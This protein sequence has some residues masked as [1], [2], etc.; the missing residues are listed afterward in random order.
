MTEALTTLADELLSDSDTEVVYGP[1]TRC[2][3]LLRYGHSRESICDFCGCP[4][5]SVLQAELAE[6]CDINPS[7]QVSP[8]EREEGRLFIAWM[9]QGSAGTTRLAEAAHSETDSPLRG[10]LHHAPTGSDQGT[11][12]ADTVPPPVPPR[13]DK[14]QDRATRHRLCRQAWTASQPAM[15]CLLCYYHYDATADGDGVLFTDLPRIWRCPRCGK[16]AFPPA[17]LSSC[18]QEYGFVARPTP[19][20]WRAG[21]GEALEDSDGSE[22][23]AWKSR[24]STESATG[25]TD[26]HSEDE[27]EAQVPGYTRVGTAEAVPRPSLVNVRTL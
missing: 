8:Q 3:R 14:P 24:T 13:A 21:R 16:A 17:G 9:V 27:D 2:K 6:T 18:N 5:C 26:E 12:K 11:S 20:H 7:T 10:P 25:A 19:R 22:S 23:D 1:G 4:E 15:H